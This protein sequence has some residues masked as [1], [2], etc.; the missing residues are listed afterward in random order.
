MLARAENNIKK[1]K[2]ILKYHDGP[3]Y[4]TMKKED[5][6]FFDEQFKQ[7]LLMNEMFK[8]EYTERIKQFEKMKK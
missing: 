2:H 1:I 6:D 5:I 3:V 8:K 4:K 7:T